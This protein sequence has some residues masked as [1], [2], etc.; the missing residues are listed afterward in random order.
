M[1][2][3][4]LIKLVSKKQLGVFYFFVSLIVF[5]LWLVGQY[6]GYYIYDTYAMMNGA[7]EGAIDG[8][9]SYL[10][11]FYINSIF[12]FNKNLAFAGGLQVLFFSLITSY[13]FL[14]LRVTCRQLGVSIFCFFLFMM[15]PFSGSFVIFY[16]RDP[17]FSWL[18]ILL[19]V[20]FFKIFSN[21]DN[22]QIGSL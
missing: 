20:F 5:G 16:N 12:S 22:R 4:E 14:P 3:F 7:K 6:P 8:W 18:F 2:Q 9:F 13:C 15:S 1:N 21:E 10:Y 19:L 17:L 11:S